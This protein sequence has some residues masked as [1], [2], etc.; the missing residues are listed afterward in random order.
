ME[1]APTRKFKHLKGFRH[2]YTF[3]IGAEYPAVLL[4]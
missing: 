4:V 3:G 2:R 1:T